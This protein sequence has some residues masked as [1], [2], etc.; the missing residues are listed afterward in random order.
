MDPASLSTVLSL[1]EPL[2]TAVIDILI[3]TTTTNI[4]VSIFGKLI[5]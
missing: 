3:V 1:C 2:S 4:L 5:V